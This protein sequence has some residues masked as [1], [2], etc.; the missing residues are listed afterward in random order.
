MF[1]HALKSLTITLACRIKA[2]FS[3][4][5]VLRHFD[6]IIP[7]HF[8]N[9]EDPWELMFK[10]VRT[11]NIYHIRNLN[12]ENFKT[13]G[14]TSIHSI[15]PQSNDILNTSCSFWKIPLYLCARMILEKKSYILAILI[16]IVFTLWIP[17]IVLST[18]QGSLNHT[19]NCCTRSFLY[20]SP[21][22]SNNFPWLHV[23]FCVMC[24]W[25]VLISYSPL[26][27]HIPKVAKTDMYKT[28]PA[29]KPTLPVLL[30]SVIVTTWARYLGVFPFL[31]LLSHHSH[32]N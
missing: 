7:L 18:P 23:Y 22:W 14:Y 20:T 21:W 32:N 17:K 9:S 1:S 16:D 2:K 3:R 4:L 13:Q 24:L 30:I 29:P 28:E 25:Y 11:I 8:K 31:S 10:W 27:L 19:S 6:I 5:L 26:Y 15:S 12:W